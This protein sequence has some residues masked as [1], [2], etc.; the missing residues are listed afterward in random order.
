MHKVK[1]IA[2]ILPQSKWIEA[3]EL[4]YVNYLQL[5]NSGPE[6]KETKCIYIW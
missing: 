5:I 1:Y 2:A 6:K 4:Y 3:P